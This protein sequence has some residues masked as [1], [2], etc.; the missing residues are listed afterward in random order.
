MKLENKVDK[1]KLFIIIKILL[2]EKHLYY[3]DNY[4]WNGLGFAKYWS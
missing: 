3:A 2:F 4:Y 1:V